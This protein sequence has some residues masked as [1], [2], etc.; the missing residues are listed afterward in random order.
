MKLSDF[1]RFELGLPEYAI[2]TFDGH[3][4][5]GC[6]LPTRDGRK[7]GNAHIIGN[8]EKVQQHQLRAYFLVITDAGSEMHLSLQEI[9]ELFYMPPYV[10]DVEEV[11]KHFRRKK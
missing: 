2:E 9:D 11:I 5:P 4:R 1:D 7:R 10:A 8:L 3:Y 6:M